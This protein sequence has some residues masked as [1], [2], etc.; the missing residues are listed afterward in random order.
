MS[1]VPIITYVMKPGD[2]ELSILQIT[3]SLR[4]RPIQRLRVLR[5]KLFQTSLKRVVLLLLNL[6]LQLQM[7]Y[8]R[9]G[10]FDD[11]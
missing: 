2:D 5:K 9:K 8:Y 7:G 4:S 1:L 3:C 10:R 6:K 11:P